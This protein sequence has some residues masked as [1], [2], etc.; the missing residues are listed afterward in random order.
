M[1][2]TS[3]K[4]NRLIGT[5]KNYEMGFSFQFYELLCLK[6]QKLGNIVPTVKRMGISKS[7]QNIY[8][9]K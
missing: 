4:I 1:P 6:L 8:K 3:P 9:K 2:C 7:H 5:R